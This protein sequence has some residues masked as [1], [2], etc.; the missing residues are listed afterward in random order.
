MRL[1]NIKGCITFWGGG[2]GVLKMKNKL[3][4]QS[5][6]SLIPRAKY[7]II[8]LNLQKDSFITIHVRLLSFAKEYFL[9]ILSILFISIF[10]IS[11][12]KKLC[13]CDTFLWV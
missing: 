12:Q 7:N 9:R 2:G 10:K 1:C 13:K 3:S 6:C 11:K 4:L 8:I 5:V